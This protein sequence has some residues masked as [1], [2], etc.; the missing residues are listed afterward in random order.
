MMHTVIGP[1]LELNDYIE[2]YWYELARQRIQN[3]LTR[4]DIATYLGVEENLYTAI[5]TDSALPTFDQALLLSL[6]FKQPYGL[7]FSVDINLF[8]AETGILLSEHDIYKYFYERLSYLLSTRR[9]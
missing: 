5:E 9:K 4:Q 8:T 6:L 2:C 3:K 7:L 1:M